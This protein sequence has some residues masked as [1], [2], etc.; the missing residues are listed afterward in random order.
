M[1]SVHGQ[2][3]RYRAFSFTA[4][5]ECFQDRQYRR[6]HKGLPGSLPRATIDSGSVFDKSMAQVLR[7]DGDGALLCVESARK[8]PKCTYLEDVLRRRRTDP[9]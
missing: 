8:I 1:A 4:L 2:N 9:Q 7:Y 3:A 6:P 5:V